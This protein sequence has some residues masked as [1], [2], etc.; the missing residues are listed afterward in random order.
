[1]KLRRL[2]LELMHPDPM[3]IA[4]MGYRIME[5]L[6]GYGPKTWINLHICPEEEEAK[7]DEG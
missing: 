1:M 2:E 4:E 6:K 3:L 7:K 5:L